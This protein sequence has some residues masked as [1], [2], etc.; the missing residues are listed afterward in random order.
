[1]VALLRNTSD[2]N[3]YGVCFMLLARPLDCPKPERRYTDT[4][5]LSAS[6][7]KEQTSASKLLASEPRP[8]WCA[9][10]NTKKKFISC[11][12]HVSVPA[13]L[14]MLFQLRLIRCTEESFSALYCSLVPAVLRSNKE[15][16]LSVQ[17]API[18]TE[19]CMVQK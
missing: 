18:D 3:L 11:F 13:F 8:Q 7:A 12:Q 2:S 6:E 10:Y 1:M 9:R 14:Y 15:A 17:R 19:I 5:S 16:C 4:S